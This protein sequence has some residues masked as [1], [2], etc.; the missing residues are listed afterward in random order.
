MYEVFD[1]VADDGVQN[2]KQDEYSH[3]QVEDIRG[4][5]DSIPRGGYVALKQHRPVLF[6]VTNLQVVP[7]HI[8]C[9]LAVLETAVNTG[10]HLM[11]QCHRC[12]INPAQSA[13]PTDHSM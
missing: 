6:P 13:H 5:V 1:E 9:L 8:H 11:P 2:A 3:D 4:Q 12:G 7:R 10:I